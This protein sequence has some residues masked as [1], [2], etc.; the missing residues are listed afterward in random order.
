MTQCRYQEPKT[1][2]AV[3]ATAK[4]VESYRLAAGATARRVTSA[5]VNMVDVP[6]PVEVDAM[7]STLKEV[8]EAFRTALAPQPP[9]SALPATTVPKGV[10]QDL[11]GDRMHIM[12]LLEG[13]MKLAVDTDRRFSMI[14]QMAHPAG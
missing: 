14:D 2:H 10:S 1:L 5:H 4:M 9:T 11:E 6:V 13:L 12:H 7:P 8:A 3:T